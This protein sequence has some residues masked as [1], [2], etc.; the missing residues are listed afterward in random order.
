MI[1]FLGYTPDAEPQTQ[2]AILDCANIIPYEAGLRTAPQATSIG[3]SAL[4]AECKGAGVLRN[5]SGSSRFLAGTAS[6]LYE[7]NGTGWADVSVTTAAYSVAAG[8]GWDFAQF[9]NTA[10]AATPS[11]RIQR[12]TSG[13]FALITAAPKATIIDS[14]NGFVMALNTDETAFG[15]SPDRWWCSAYL[16]DTDW[17]PAVSTQA[18]T[19]R[20]VDGLGKLTAGRRFGTDFVAY[21]ER[22]VF[23]GR[24]AGPPEVW[25][26]TMVSE[27]VGC[28]GKDALAVT[29]IGHVFVGVDNVYLFDG[30]RPVP[31]ATGSVRQWW[32]DNS[33]GQYRARTKL[34]WDRQ[35]SAVWMYFPSEQSS[36]LC[37]RCIVFHTL[38]RRWGRADNTV[39]AVVNYYTSGA[40]T[41]DGS[42]PLIST[43]NASPG[44]GIPFDSV[45]W[46]AEKEVPAIFGTDNQLKAL[47][48]GADDSYLTTGDIGSDKGSTMCKRVIVNFSQSPEVADI[49]G[50]TKS[51]SG[52]T[53]TAASTSELNDAAFDV[54]QT[55]R[56]H[57]FKISFSGDAKF[58]GFDLEI[59]Q[60]GGR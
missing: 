38:T 33:S 7:S 18:T 49:V 46:L 28:V 47:E 1:E 60:A 51:G 50:Y 22:G 16:D 39:Q 6:A 27:D 30:T 48:A 4:A 53:L 36:G 32:L 31:L 37:D 8:D 55:G 14:V 12:S 52:K 29:N 57:R 11:Q 13:S 19:G 20:L 35:N 54:R 23:L 21:K 26:W 24:Y 9:G 15:T 56:F 58:N 10:L 34:L 41:Y 25:Q 17:T 45:I 40:F 2:G 3:V 44:A 42:S 43:Y 59:E 5:L